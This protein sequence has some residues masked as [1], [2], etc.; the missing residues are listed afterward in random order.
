MYIACA[1]LIGIVADVLISVFMRYVLNSAPAWA[2]QVAL[3]LVINVAM[4]GASA[5]VRDEGH[6]GMESLIGLLPKNAQFWIGSLVGVFT[7]VFGVMLVWGSTMM[8]LSVMGGTIPTLGVTEFFR[9]LPGMIA[10]VLITLFSI[11]HLI[12]MFTDKE[13]IPSWH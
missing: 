13:V 6:I 5:G 10:G 2:E 7:V 3:L 8:G 12:A 11:E 1:G 4:F 9:Y